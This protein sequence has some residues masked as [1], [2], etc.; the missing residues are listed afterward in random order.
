MLLIDTLFQLFFQIAADFKNQV[1]WGHVRRRRSDVLL[2]CFPSGLPPL[3]QH[4]WYCWKPEDAWPHALLKCQRA[5]FNEEEE[6]K[7]KKTCPTAQTG[8]CRTKLVFLFL[9]NIT[10]CKFSCAR[11]WQWWRRI[12]KCSPAQR[13]HS[14]SEVATKRQVP[15]F[16]KGLNGPP[17]VEDDHKVRHLEQRGKKLKK[18]INRKFVFHGSVILIE[19]LHNWAE[20]WNKKNSVG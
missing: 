12:N 16:G 7:Q 9:Q 20:N 4:S 5:G 8:Q 18:Q 6:K 2:L 1:D 3:P 19:G 10:S 11:K 17:L 13:S 14:D 15:T